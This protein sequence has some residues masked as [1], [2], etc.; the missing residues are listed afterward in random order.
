MVSLFIA[1]GS[2]VAAAAGAYVS[3]LKSDAESFD[4]IKFL[5]T[6]ILAGGVG[7]VISLW[8]ISESVILISPTYAYISDILENLIKA[9][10]R[11]FQKRQKKTSSKK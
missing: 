8:N 3:Y 7:F 2:A 6:V 11:K 1:I 9:I 5:K 10:Y 4:W